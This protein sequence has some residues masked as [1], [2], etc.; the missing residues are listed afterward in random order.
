MSQ[1]QNFVLFVSSFFSLNRNYLITETVTTERQ[2]WF[3]E[4]L[5]LSDR[6]TT[7][8]LGHDFTVQGRTKR[9]DDEAT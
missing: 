1:L 2:R 7:V 8:W 5:A 9:R 3:D 6:G 4:L